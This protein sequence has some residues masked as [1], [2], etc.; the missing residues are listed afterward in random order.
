MSHRLSRAAARVRAMSIR[1]LT[2]VAPVIS[3]SRRLGMSVL[4]TIACLLFFPLLA[5]AQ[6][7][8]PPVEETFLGSLA[9]LQERGEVQ[10]RSLVRAGGTRSAPTALAP[11]EFELGIT[12]ALELTLESG[13]S[14]YRRPDGWSS[15]SRAD[16]GAGLRVGGQLF[17]RLHSAVSL[18]VGSESGEESDS[19]RETSMGL[20]IQLGIDL[21]RLRSSHLFTSAGFERAVRDASAHESDW[22]VGIVVPVGSFRGTL[23]HRLVASDASERVTIPGIIWQAGAGWEL[24]LATSIATQSRPRPHGLL[25]SI[26]V[27]F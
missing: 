13:G 24:G 12:D 17:D 14:R 9:F 5:R 25:M 11:I 20:G 7:S 26:L 22:T 8:L 6:S 2:S 18:E 3:L 21:P 15:P 23:E 10:V 16:F 19:R 4:I 1:S 27:E